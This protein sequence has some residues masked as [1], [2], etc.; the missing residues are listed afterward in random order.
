MP[1]RPRPVRPPEVDRRTFL[2]GTAAAGLLLGAGVTGCGVESSSDGLG[3]RLV[4][5]Q[6][7]EMENLDPAF[8]AGRSDYEV[9][10]CVY[11]GLVGYRPGTMDTVDAV[12]EEFEVSDDGTRIRFRV[13][14]G[15]RFH[16]G[17]GEVTAEDVK[18]SYERIAGVG[19]H[20]L[21]SPYAGDWAPLDQVR[22]LVDYVGRLRAD[23]TDPP[24]RPYDIV[25]G[26]ATPDDSAKAR[27]L[28]APLADAGATWWDERQ[29]QGSDDLYRRDPVLRRIEAG[30]PTL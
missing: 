1:Q 28:I 15:V 3:S 23:E 26:G 22:D 11:E 29:L 2:R 19:G 21:D 16:A 12:A 8:A 9:M 20:D 6:Q 27:D 5:R 18:F 10:A 13:R 30:P 4:I 14:P 24:A 17:Y 7:L 25:L